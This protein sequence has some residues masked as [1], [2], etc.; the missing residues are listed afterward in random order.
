MEIL[1][2]VLEGRRHLKKPNNNP[3]VNRLGCWCSAS[4]HFPIVAISRNAANE[5]LTADATIPIES[6]LSRVGP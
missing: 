6:R 3:F 4:N 5:E 1:N 2:I